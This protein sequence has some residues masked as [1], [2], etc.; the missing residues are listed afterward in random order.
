MSLEGTHEENKQPSAE[1]L[2]EAMEFDNWKW[3]PELLDVGDRVDVQDWLSG[4]WELSV[5]EEIK[6]ERG[7]L[8]L[9]SCE[10]A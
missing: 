10:S 9:V 5:V 1:Q 2:A 8:V 3:S 6:A 4:I 7:G